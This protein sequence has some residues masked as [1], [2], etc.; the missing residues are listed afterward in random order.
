MVTGPKYKMG[1]AIRLRRYPNGPDFTIVKHM[2]SPVRKENVYEAALPK[3]GSTALVWEDDIL[4]PT[5]AS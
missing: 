5:V 4:P 3:S 2:T 1:D